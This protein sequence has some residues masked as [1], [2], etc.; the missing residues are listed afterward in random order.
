M[1]R[2]MYL[3]ETK[4]N[5]E[6]RTKMLIAYDEQNG[7]ANSDLIVNYDTVRSN[8]M[9]WDYKRSLTSQYHIY[10]FNKQL[11]SSQNRRTIKFTRFYHHKYGQV[12]PP[13]AHW[14]FG[15]SWFKTSLNPSSTPPS[16]RNLFD[17]RSRIIF[18]TKRSTKCLKHHH[19]D[20]N[21]TFHCSDT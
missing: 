4:G 3:W 19:I 8:Q 10:I 7:C 11:Y 17:W 5:H 14:I 20:H 1:Q 15:V 9:Y 2:M 16:F 18:W 21:E 6:D 13:R 12:H